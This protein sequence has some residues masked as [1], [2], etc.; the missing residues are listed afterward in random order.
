VTLAEERV[1]AELSLAS[2]EVTLLLKIIKEYETR[3]SEEDLDAEGQI[4]HNMKML[5]TAVSFEFLL[6]PPDIQKGD[7]GII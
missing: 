4:I 7:K 2:E 3:M 6:D 5:F 1:W